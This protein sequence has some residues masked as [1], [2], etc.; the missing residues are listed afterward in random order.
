MGTTQKKIWLSGLS[1]ALIPL[2]IWVFTG[3]EIFTKTKILIE[4]EDELFGTKYLE[5]HETFILGLDYTAAIIL[6]I[7]LITFLTNLF[8]KP[9]KV[10]T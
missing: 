10:K 8:F 7:L 5:W 9:K 6:S 1:L 4:K 3:M 2:I